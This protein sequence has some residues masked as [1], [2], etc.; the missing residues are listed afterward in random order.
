MPEHL[1]EGLPGKIL[2]RDAALAVDDSHFD[3]LDDV[4]VFEATS[5][6]GFVDEHPN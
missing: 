3:G 6:P 4:F 2:H 1:L 5:Q